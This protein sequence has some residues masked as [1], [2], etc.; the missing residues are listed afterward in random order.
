MYQ[1]AGYVATHSGM[2]QQ[3]RIR[4]GEVVAALL[5]YAVDQAML[6]GPKHAE[7]IL[8]PSES[9]DCGRPTRLYLAPREGFVCGPGPRQ[10][11]IFRVE[12]TSR[13]G[14]ASSLEGTYM[15]IPKHFCMGSVI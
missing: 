15:S 12:N 5:C 9:V 13:L 11:S 7:T 8:Y 2:P 6:E 14:N 10:W 1:V 4:G 3:L